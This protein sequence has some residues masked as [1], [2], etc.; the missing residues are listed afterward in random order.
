MGGASSRL[1]SRLKIYRDNT[2]CEDTELDVRGRLALYLNRGHH[3]TLLAAHETITTNVF[4]ALLDRKTV[5][6]DAF[7]H[8]FEW[9]LNPD[10][11]HG[12]N[13]SIRVQLIAFTF[14]QSYAKCKA[15]REYPVS[16]QTDGKGRF[17]DLAFGIPDLVN[18][19]RLIVMED[20]SSGQ[21]RKL[22]SLVTYISLAHE[23]HLKATI[24]AVVVSDKPVGQKLPAVVYETLKTEA[25]DFV[26]AT[27]W[28]L[29]PL[30]TIGT[31]IQVALDAR[32][33][34]L[35]DRMKFVLEDL[36]EWCQ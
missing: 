18:P 9:L 4:H 1:V 20:I 35:T 7:W 19:E 36:V 17:V 3:M 31:W 15:M 33:E 16:G 27:G 12:L 25:A 13:D 11:G 22:E 24:R 23:R 30:Q 32:R 26:A 34:N 8:L 29:L 14:G 5:K 6:W 21:M 2:L 28:K 10:E